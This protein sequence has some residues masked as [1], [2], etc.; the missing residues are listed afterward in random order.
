VVQD[1]VIG[2]ERLDRV[3]LLLSSDSRDVDAYGVIVDSGTT[4]GFLSLPL[5]IQS[6]EFYVAA[7]K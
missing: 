5:T 1:G 6:T 4:D 7:W 3:G 2:S